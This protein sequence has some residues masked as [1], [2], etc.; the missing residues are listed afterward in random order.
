MIRARGS[1]LFVALA[2]AATGCGGTVGAQKRS[3]VPAAGGSSVRSMQ[4]VTP[5]EGWVL[6]DE[7][8]LW[9]SGSPGASRS[10]TPA[11]QA[12][13][14]IGA[15]FFVDAPH[16]WVAAATGRAEQATELTI[17]RT[18]NNGSTWTPAKLTTSPGASDPASFSFVDLRHGWLLVDVESSSNFNLG[19]LYRTSDGGATWSKVSA[20]SGGT[21]RF[22]T[23]TLGFL[24]GGPAGDKLYVTRDGGSS[25]QPQTVPLPQGFAD[26][27]P[28]YG[29]PVFTG[30]RVGV[31]PVTLSGIAMSAV[32]FYA[33]ADAGASWEVAAVRLVP[34]SLE[35]GAAV[36][37]DVLGADSW[38]TVS[39]SG[40][41]VFLTED[42]GRSWRVVAPNGLPAGVSQV[43]FATPARGWSLISAGECPESKDNCTLTREVR[44]TADGGQTWDLVA[45]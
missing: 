16:G 28:V 35:Q 25:W 34:G 3:A 26:A 4:L 19:E 39:P 15:V 18:E 20:P 2:I 6:T 41:R 23:Q 5:S 29:T 30:A 37:S 36:P 45:G 11:N 14:A 27:V 22:A 42:R 1:L 21:I 40:A 9:T 8:L 17:F 10:I 43:D 44:K 38:V 12:P 33:T 13:A 24:A 31:L 32:V 7:A